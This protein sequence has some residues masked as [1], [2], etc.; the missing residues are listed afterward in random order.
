MSAL[1]LI[2]VLLL[3]AGAWWLVNKKYGAVIAQPF[4]FLINV[5]IIGV[6]IFYFLIATGLWA[7][8]KGVKVPSVM[9][10]KITINT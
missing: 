3:C 4:K 2:I 10:H 8:I 1:Y 6:A 9:T 5:V 7:K